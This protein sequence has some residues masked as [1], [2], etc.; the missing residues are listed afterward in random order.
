[1]SSSSGGSSG[2]GE[3]SWTMR[4]LPEPECLPPSSV[5]HTSVVTNGVICFSETQIA[6]VLSAGSADGADLA[7]HTTQC[8]DGLPHLVA[9]AATAGATAG[10]F[11]GIERV[12]CGRVSS[13]KR[14]AATRLRGW[15]WS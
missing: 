10:M 9:W 13:N 3:A 2:S 6:F 8:D 11:D 15:R 5:I 14:R 1:M 7:V 4:P 12:D